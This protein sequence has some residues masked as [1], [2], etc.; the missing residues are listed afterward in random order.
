MRSPSGSRLLSLTQLR[1]TPLLA[2][3]LN[4]PWPARVQRLGNQA[5]RRVTERFP[6]LAELLE[7]GTRSVRDGF[8]GA[9]QSSYAT[10]ATHVSSP[11]APTSAVA[12]ADVLSADALQ[13]ALTAP[14]WQTR[15]EAIAR[16]GEV[17]SLIHVPALIGALRDESAE[18]A[19]AAALALGKQ[20]S[21][22]AS[23]ALR[24]VLANREGYFSPVTRA[25]AVQGLARC[26]PASEL[27]P[28][29]AALTDVDAEVSLAAI[30]A[31][32]ECAPRTAVED[33]LPLLQDVSGYFLPPVRLAAATAL[34]RT[35]ALSQHE[36]SGL[37]A[38]EQ[39]PAIAAVFASA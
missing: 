21:P 34:A 23:D 3:V 35:G 24:D 27:A 39:D 9:R 1:L 18:V 10:E 32:A 19:A 11:A 25:A 38:R 2:R 26:L 4:R 5:L 8:L 31:L 37:L 6:A 36:L 17:P 15:A 12:F 16:C 30:A 28:L 13:A 14:S 33:L 20:G 7:K 22:Y 29:R